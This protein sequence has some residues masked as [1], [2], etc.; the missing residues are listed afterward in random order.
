MPHP[1]AEPDKSE[2]AKENEYG[3]PPDRDEGSAQERDGGTAKLA[4]GAGG[5]KPGTFICR[6]PACGDVVQGWQRNTLAHP[7]EEP[8]HYERGD[9]VLRGQGREDREDRPNEHRDSQ[10]GLAWTRTAPSLRLPALFYIF[11][12]GKIRN[13]YPLIEV[14]RWR[15]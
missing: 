10:Y 11:L 8:A 13:K 1:E 5:Y 4:T 2:R 9:A 15:K 3:R 7:E 6:R 14:A 12:I